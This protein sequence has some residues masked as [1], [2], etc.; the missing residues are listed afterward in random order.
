MV[1]GVAFGVSVVVMMI[2][3][4]RARRRWKR[5]DPRHRPGLVANLGTA[6]DA[7][8]ALVA[9]GVILPVMQTSPDGVRTFTLLAASLAATSLGLR[10]RADLATIRDHRR[11]ID[12]VDGAGPRSNARAKE[13]GGPNTRRSFS[14]AAPAKL[15]RVLSAM[16]DL[17]AMQHAA[18]ALWILNAE[19]L[20]NDPADEAESFA[21]LGVY[22]ALL[23][24]FVAFGFVSLRLGGP[25]RL[26]DNSVYM[27]RASDTLW[28]AWLWWRL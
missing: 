22:A 18:I 7:F 27:S 4:Q 17:R 6:S 28:F 11:E 15:V 23:H 12:L 2:E 26:V 16:V 25:H 8:G 21:S 14:A 20:I 10:V 13:G 3:K 1:A 5:S 24:G 9:F 19:W